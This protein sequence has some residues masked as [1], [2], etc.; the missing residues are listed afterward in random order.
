VSPIRRFEISSCHLKFL[1]ELKSIINIRRAVESF[2]IWKYDNGL[3]VKANYQVSTAATSVCK[4][5]PSFDGFS[6]YRVPPTRRVKALDTHPEFSSDPRGEINI[7]RTIER[8]L[9]RNM[10]IA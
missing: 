10:K 1:P 5:V 7:S 4:T 6:V 8:F 2:C 3:G 9:L